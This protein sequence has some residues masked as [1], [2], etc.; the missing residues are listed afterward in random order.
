MTDVACFCG[1]VYSFC[2]DIGV[3]PGCGEYA[4]FS[5]VTT[6]E[7]RQMRRELDA[8]LHPTAAELAEC[9]EPTNGP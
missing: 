5:G 8:V 9:D 3:C 2:G 1:C 4:T 7:A 6:A